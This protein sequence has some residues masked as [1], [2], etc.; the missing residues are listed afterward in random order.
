MQRETINKLA[1]I[2]AFFLHS[3]ILLIHFKYPLHQPANSYS[4]EIGHLKVKDSVEKTDN[5]MENNESIETVTT[6]L[7]KNDSEPI[8]QKHK[9]KIKKNHINPESDHIKNSHTVNKEVDNRSIYD[10]TDN[11]Q[12]KKTAIQLDMEGWD[13]D[14]VP[15]PNDNTDEIG[16]IVFEI[17]IDNSGFVVGVREVEKTISPQLSALYKESLTNLTFSKTSEEV[18]NQNITK[19]T[20]TFILH[21]K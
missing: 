17:I 11:N 15:H 8:V 3:L 12:Q 10:T 20:V 4:I 1:L 6:E 21:S 7:Q 18:L 9:H 5:L 19:G 2:I 16:K 13:W 14:A